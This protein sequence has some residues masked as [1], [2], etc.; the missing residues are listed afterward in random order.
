MFGNHESD[1]IASQLKAAH[2]DRPIESILRQSGGQASCQTLKV[3]P[4]MDA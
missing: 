4:V 2:V 3:V 1:A